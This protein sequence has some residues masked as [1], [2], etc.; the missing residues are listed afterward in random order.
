MLGK[1]KPSFSLKKTAEFV[2]DP[3]F[4]STAYKL[5]FASFFFFFFLILKGMIS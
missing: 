4:L 2:S 3:G 1:A 5:K